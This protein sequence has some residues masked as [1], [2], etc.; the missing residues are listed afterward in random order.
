[1]DVIE[2]LIRAGLT[3]VALI[4]IIGLIAALFMFIFRLATDIDE[5]IQG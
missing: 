1:M 2:G 3:V 4:L 5:Q